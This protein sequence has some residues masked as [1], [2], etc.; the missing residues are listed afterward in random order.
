M[1]PMSF[2]TDTPTATSMTKATSTICQLLNG[3]LPKQVWR[4][5]IVSSVVVGEAHGLRHVV[6]CQIFFKVMVWRTRSLTAV[7]FRK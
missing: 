1:R 4:G 3:A 2:S 6:A 7:C 5:E